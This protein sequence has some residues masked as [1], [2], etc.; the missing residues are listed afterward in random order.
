M[1][2]AIYPG[3]DI[4]TYPMQ[5]YPNGHHQPGSYPTMQHAYPPGM[6]PNLPYVGGGPGGMAGSMVGVAF[7]PGRAYESLG[8]DY[9]LPNRGYAAENSWSGWDLAQAQYGGRDPGFDRGWFD[10]IIGSVSSFFSSRRMRYDDAKEAHRRIYHYKEYQTSGFEDISSRVLGGAAAFQAF[11][12]WDKEHFSVYHERPSQENRE[13]LISLAVGERE[14][15]SALSFSIPRL[16]LI[17]SPL[18]YVSVLSLRTS[19]T[20]AY[21]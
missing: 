1:P 8:Y 13:R 5:Y 20:A 7:H 19:G 9:Q 15:W 17:L 14:Y 10:G 18:S 6:N 3:D 16:T 12:I 11:L 21:H 2:T 4:K